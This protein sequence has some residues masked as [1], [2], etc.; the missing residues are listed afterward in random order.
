MKH[1]K[2]VDKNFND[3][4]IVYMYHDVTICGFYVLP[5]NNKYYDNHLDILETF[6]TK[7]DAN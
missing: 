2:G 3:G 6:T 7:D 1:V 4:I 5:I